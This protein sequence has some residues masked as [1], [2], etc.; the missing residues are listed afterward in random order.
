MTHVRDVEEAML[1]AGGRI[2]VPLSESGELDKALRFLREGDMEALRA[3]LVRLRS[4]VAQGYHRNPAPLRIGARF[5]TGTAVGILGEV[6]EVKYQHQKDKK[7]YKHDF[8]GS[9]IIYAV[10]REEH[11]DLLITHVSGEP[12]WQDFP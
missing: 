6:E 2:R 3:V 1:G 10:Q 11:R 5:Q 4:Q 8:S 9:G 7:F 12:L